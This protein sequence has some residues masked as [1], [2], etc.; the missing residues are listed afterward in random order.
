[1][2]VARD[3]SNTLLYSARVEEEGQLAVPYD[4]H[5]I[6]EGSA[7]TQF[8]EYGSTLHS[9]E[10]HHP[11]KAVVTEDSYAILTT[12]GRV[13]GGGSHEPS[14]DLTDVVDLVST[15][16]AFAAQTRAGNVQFW[17]DENH[18]LLP[19]ESGVSRLQVSGDTIILKRPGNSGDA[20]LNTVTAT[21]TTSST[22]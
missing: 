8:R 3:A 4:I 22:V 9:F 21:L 18:A 6:P 2:I 15:K 14:S 17:G 5:K 20:E 7:A 12:D 11:R 13:V 19:E 16:H 10:R 1:M